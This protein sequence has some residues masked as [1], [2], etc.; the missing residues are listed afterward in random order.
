MKPSSARAAGLCVRL[1]V[2]GGGGGRV[3]C[4]VFGYSGEGFGAVSLAR[5]A[6]KG[7][8]KIKGEVCV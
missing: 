1:T 2:G 4:F 7:E 3:V 5:L 8:H 6:S